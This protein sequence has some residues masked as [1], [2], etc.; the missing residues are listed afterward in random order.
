MWLNI[1]DIDVDSLIYDMIEKKF[2]S[3]S[4][5]ITTAENAKND[6]ENH[7]VSRKV[8][9]IIVLVEYTIMIFLKEAQ[10]LCSL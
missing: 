7:N 9:A 4:L 3:I 10:N 5:N 2:A 6:T 1:L 8:V